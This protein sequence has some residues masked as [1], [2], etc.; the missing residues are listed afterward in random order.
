MDIEAEQVVDDKILCNL[1]KNKKKRILIIAVVLALIILPSVWLLI[2][3]GK[4]SV[5]NEP[6]IENSESR[7][8]TPATPQTINQPRKI[9]IVGPIPGAEEE[10]KDFI[11]SVA[12]DGS[13]VMIIYPKKDFPDDGCEITGLRDISRDGNWILFN[14]KCRNETFAYIIKT[15]GSEVKK[16]HTGEG[17]LFSPDGKLIVIRSQVPFKKSSTVTIVNLEGNFVYFWGDEVAPGHYPSHFSSDGKMIIM[18]TENNNYY[19]V[20]LE[21]GQAAQDYNIPQ[22]IPSPDGKKILKQ[23][24]PDFQIANA[25]GSNAHDIEKAEECMYLLPCWSQDGQSILVAVTHM[26]FDKWS[27]QILEL[28]EERTKVLQSKIVI[29]SKFKYYIW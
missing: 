1:E 22:G 26:N 21:T 13:D 23:K 4:S 9:Y 15:D 11:Y 27:L 3:K 19:G 5:V 28:N 20:A 14:Q 29:E 24:I 25:D 17:L 8:S 7:I 12:L 10:G 2:L 6:A 18:L 16:I